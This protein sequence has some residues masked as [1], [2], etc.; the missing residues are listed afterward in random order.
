MR[1]LLI[2]LVASASLGA[3]GVAW[4]IWRTFP[5]S[6]G[7]VRVAGH[8]ASTRIETDSRGIPT[9]RARSIPDAFFGLGYVHAKDRL[10]QMEFQRRVGAGRLSEILG[11]GALPA[12]RFLR[13][14]G[15]H[16]AAE[17]AWRSLPAPQKRLLEAYA[18]GVNG[19]LA[20][21]GAR[22]IE[23]LILRVAPEPWQPVDSLAWTK[24]MAWDLAGNAREE[25]RRA[26]FAGAVGP[27][28]A[29]ELLPLAASEPTILADGEWQ[30]A[31]VS[32]AISDS[33]FPIPG[34]WS[35]LDR[36]FASLDPLGLAAGEDLGS[37]SWVLA[38]S[39][40]A[41]GRPILAN[42]P[43]LGL[44]APSV[45]YLAC[46][47]APG[48][49]AVGATLPGV[50][51][52]IIGR[53]DRIAWG[54]TSLEPDVQDLFV[55]TVDPQDPSRY[56][57]RGEWRSF[58]TRVE[59]I[60][61]RGGKE[62]DLVV[63]GSVHGPIV[64]GV[65]SGAETL[66]SAV[67][68]R[69]TGL[70]GGDNTAGAFFVINTARNWNEFLSGVR[71]LQ[72]PP[73]NFVYADVEGQIGY[74]AS[75]AMPIRP[76]ANGLLP[77]SGSGEDD[78]MGTIPFETLPRVLNPARRFV[79]TANNRVVSAAYPHSFGLTW[80]EPY[81]AR[82]I[83]EMI[84]SR[85]R[86][87]PADVV[88][89][90]LDRRSLQAEELLPLLLRDTAPADAASRDAL[91]WLARWDRE[92]AP[93]SVAAAIY[94][95]WFVELAKMPEDELEGVPRGRTRGRF[96][97]NALR[98]GAAWCD[99]V[100]TP[101]VEP[102]ADFQAAALQRAVAFLAER[103]GSDPAGWKWA[104]LHRATFA[105]GVF[106]DVRVL[107]RLF[108]LEA[109]HGGDAS[110]VDVGAYSQDGDFTMTDGASYRQ[111]IDLANPL[112]SRFVHTT[113]QSGN[114]FSRRYR[115]FLPLWRAGELFAIGREPPV[116]TLVLEP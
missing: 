27:E 107:K 33:R 101:R 81:R 86:V 20:A 91:E 62:E 3:A 76:R 28:K 67:A 71:Q 80:A 12:D 38:G 92:M 61:I 21:D 58:E 14:V 19:F 7:T 52:V 111:V 106:G 15:F 74:A 102:C 73:Q 88:A 63:R 108:S 29:A 24:M 49:R 23:F 31:P 68:L 34:P 94:A 69:W 79:A 57:H 51:G 42:D 96:L 37:N 54:L 11:A 55:E 9:I 8:A 6:S 18:A 46:L 116:R 53:N 98:E 65:L 109:G 83:S 47:D 72:S 114:P 22:P 90:Q 43:H 5:G 84:E 50:P 59:K 40:T 82:R 95:A 4:V 25:I 70:D 78:W 89:M 10:W 60:R 32:P 45:W 13:T 17:S 35:S 105:H 93:D 87:T 99:D 104:R 30:A 44:R 113:G 103:L 115:D 36:V 16:R 64:T 77:V 97:I 2:L 48:L 39:R 75:G 85:P 1:R 56:R 26:R 66:G 112:E 110:T 100:R 41:S